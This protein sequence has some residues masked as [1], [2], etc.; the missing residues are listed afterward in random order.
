M[1]H[2]KK[3]KME[4]IGLEIVSEDVEQVWLLQF[5]IRWELPVHFIQL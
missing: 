5:T 3:S 4:I 1:S 2:L